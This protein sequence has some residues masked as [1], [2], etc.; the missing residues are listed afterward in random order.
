LRRHFEQS[1]HRIRFQASLRFAAAFEI[2]SV[3]TPSTWQGGAAL[4]SRELSFE[5]HLL[6]NR[7]SKHRK[8]RGFDMARRVMFATIVFLTAFFVQPPKMNRGSQRSA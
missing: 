6:W 4:A 7:S 3:F 8:K 2:C 1:C 5:R